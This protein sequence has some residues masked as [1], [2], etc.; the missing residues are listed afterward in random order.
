MRA[1]CV[2]CLTKGSPDKEQG[3][4]PENQLAEFA[5]GAKRGGDTRPQCVLPTSQN[6]LLWNSSRLSDA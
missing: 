2:S 3:V 5:K 6:P 1:T 4:A